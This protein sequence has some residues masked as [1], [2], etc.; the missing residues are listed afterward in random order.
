MNDKNVSTK[1]LVAAL[2]V[3]AGVPLAAWADDVVKLPKKEFAADKGP[4]TVDVAAFPD[5]I[6]DAYKT[7]STKCSKCHTLA[8]PINTDMT[9]DSWKMYV[10]RMSNK[11]DSAISPDQGKTIYKFLKFYQGEKDA[12]KAK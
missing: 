12:K 8:R 9:A 5:D 10:K 2:L 3:L 11:P 4:E 6:K 7:F 1:R